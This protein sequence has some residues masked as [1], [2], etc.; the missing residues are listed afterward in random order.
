MDHI[1]AL[2]PRWSRKPLVRII[3]ASDAIPSGKLR[4]SRRI[5]LRLT[6]QFELL[7]I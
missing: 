7:L 5:P 6:I 2:K 1:M 3:E 4:V